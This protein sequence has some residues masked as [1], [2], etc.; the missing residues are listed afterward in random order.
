MASLFM[1]VKAFALQR[2]MGKFLT[3]S[4]NSVDDEFAVVLC[5]PTAHILSE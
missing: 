2:P 4:S 1:N 5:D 3:S